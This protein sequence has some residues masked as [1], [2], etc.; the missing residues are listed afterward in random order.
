MA[1]ISQKRVRYY[2]SRRTARRL[3]RKSKYRFI[4]TISVIIFL[5]Y[6]TVIWILPY[7]I[8]GVGTVKNIIKPPQTVNQK[9]P[10]N[11]AAAPPVLSI[12]Y[13]ATNSGE[14][15]I[16]GFGVPDSRVKLYLDDKPTQTADVSSDGSFNF[17]NISLNLGI[18]NI[19]ATTLDDLNKESL[20]SKTLKLTYINEK[21]SLTLNSP[22]DNTTTTGM[23]K[24]ITVSGKV[25]PGIGILVNGSQVVVGNDGSFSTDVALNEGDNTISV[26]ATDTALNSTEI[27]RKVIYKP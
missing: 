2:H 20:P 21:P 8:G 15:N 5:I 6:A 3:V 10:Q 14:I 23:D 11:A 9:L 4:V 17:T 27:E 16:Q 26:K 24:K 12:P 22:A 7:F 18:N 13:E 25:E 19:Y 1:A